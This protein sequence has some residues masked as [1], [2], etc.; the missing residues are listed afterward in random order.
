MSG[1]VQ[2]SGQNLR[3]VNKLQSIEQ[4]RHSVD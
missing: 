3:E 1:T 2:R 4:S